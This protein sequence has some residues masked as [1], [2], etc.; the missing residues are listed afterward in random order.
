MS[1]LLFK[2]IP[3]DG[4]D[5][6]NGINERASAPTPLRKDESLK[7]KYITEDQQLFDT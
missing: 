6:V 2:N 5:S 4:F 7:E 3:K 1:K